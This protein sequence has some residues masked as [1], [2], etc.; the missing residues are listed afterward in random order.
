MRVKATVLKQM[1]KNTK[2]VLINLEV[3]L[4]T[5]TLIVLAFY[6]HSVLLGVGAIIGFLN[7]DSNDSIKKNERK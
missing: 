6:Y 5:I 1:D 4:I 3:I 7:I 2:Y